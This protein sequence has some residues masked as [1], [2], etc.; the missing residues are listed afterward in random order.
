MP[1]LNI[2]EGKILIIDDEEGNIR[3]LERL[4]RGANFLNI[5]SIS[6]SR[7]AV[8]TYHSYQ[9]DLIILDL[10]MPNMDG[11]EVMGELKKI[12]V[13]T[14]IPILVLTAQREH[15]TRLKAL[16]SGAK[17]FLTKPFELAEALTRVSNLMEVKLLNNQIHDHNNNLETLV[18]DRTR[19]L[20]QTRLEIIHRLG[21]A[22]E[23][24]DNET[25]RHVIRLS[26][27]TERLAREIGMSEDDCK[28]LLHAS[29]L[30]DVGKIGISDTIL[31]KEGELTPEEWE[32][33]KM[34][35]VI[36]AEILSGSNSKMMKM[37][38]TICL[39]HQE[40]WDGLGYPLGLKGEEIPLVGR[41]VA[42]CDVF[43]ALTSQRP[44]KKAYS[45]E[46]AMEI[47][48]SKSGTDFE[49]RLVETFKKVL[50]DMLD[51]VQEFADGEQEEMLKSFGS[52]TQ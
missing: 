28:L 45:I 34:H 7:L 14:Y 41:I 20:E 36:G 39:T 19:E 6:D 30:H 33:M 3:V 25:G 18:R 21:R 43:D 23:F 50:P 2:E 13:E 47:I 38:E 8:E 37:A 27:M 42:V 10:K 22:A 52:M 15:S 44:Y 24:R 26:H 16:E 29:P 1:R 17:D 46:K 32:A 51:I 31:L 35:P 12:N 11:F 4:L 40:R 49:P 48:E 5:K 9:P